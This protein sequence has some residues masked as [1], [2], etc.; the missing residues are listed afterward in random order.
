MAQEAMY[1]P[2]FVI[3]CGCLGSTP[4]PKFQAA[5]GC[6]HGSIFTASSYCAHYVLR[7]AGN[8]HA[9]RVHIFSPSSTGKRNWVMIA[10]LCV[11]NTPTSGSH[12]SQLLRSYY[13]ISL[14]IKTS[15]NTI[16]LKQ[17]LSL[18]VKPCLKLVFLTHK[19]V[20]CGFKL[21]VV[22]YTCFPKHSQ[23]KTKGQTRTESQQ[24]NCMC[25]L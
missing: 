24:V 15:S 18:S 1:Q 21:C 6:R 12:A 9:K 25:R 22:V 20:A 2:V 3:I 4:H 7:E 19:M 13:C 17:R 11:Q 14:T 10:W 5:S 16:R 23:S 8:M